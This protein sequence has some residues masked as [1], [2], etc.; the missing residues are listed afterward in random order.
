M[1]MENKGIDCQSMMCSCSNGK[2]Q[3]VQMKGIR[4]VSVT[5]DQFYEI[6]SEKIREQ[7]INTNIVFESSKSQSPLLAFFSEFI[8]YLY[9]QETLRSL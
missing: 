4:E 6:M 9:S 1:K 3:S 7:Q 8:G 5:F 2:P